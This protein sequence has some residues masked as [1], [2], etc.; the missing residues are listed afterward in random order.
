[1]WK[2]I[3]KIYFFSSK[4]LDYSYGYYQSKSEKIGETPYLEQYQ[5]IE[6]RMCGEDFDEYIP[7]KTARALKLNRFQCP[8]Y[9]DWAIGGSK[10][11]IQY[12]YLEAR[13]KR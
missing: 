1:M 4:F 12:N 13:V 8:V 9:P 2:E 6:T 11:G 7:F 10:T 3:I 5:E